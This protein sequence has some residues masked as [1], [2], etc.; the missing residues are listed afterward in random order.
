MALGQSRV[1]DES[2]KAG[3][4]LSAKQYFLVKLDASAD[5]VLAA[6]GTDKI[7]GVLQNDPKSG[8]VG[9]VRVLGISLVTLGGTVAIGDEMTSD[10]AGKGVVSTTAGDR[11]IGEALRAGVS[12]DTIE[13]FMPGPWDQHA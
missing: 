9:T 6:A 5:I 8:E 7:K 2:F 12:G 4:D 10:S 11:M 3:A 1:W 13:M